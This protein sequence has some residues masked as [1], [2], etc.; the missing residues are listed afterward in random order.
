MSVRA[1]LTEPSGK[2][3]ELYRDL[4]NGRVQCTACARNC[5]I[6][7]GQVG[8]CGVRGVVGG[9]LYLL[10]YGKVM[11]GHIDPIEKKPVVHY[12]PGSKVFSIATSGCSWACAYC[13][14]PGTPVLTDRGIMSIDQIYKSS[15]AS[16]EIVFPDS[17]RVLSHT[18][19]W[20][21]VDKAFRH[22]Y[23]GRMLRIRPFYLPEFQC[24]PN[25]N[26]FV[27]DRVSGELI[28]RRADMLQPGDY[29]VVPRP[30]TTL[31]SS[32]LDTAMVLLAATRQSKEGGRAN[33]LTFDAERVRF[34][35][36]KGNGIP[37]II[38]LDEEF[39]ELLGLY[40]AEGSSIK[41]SRRPNSWSVCL[42]F[43]SHE[44]DL[45]V[46]AED[47]LRR[48]FGVS[49]YRVT[50]GSVTRVTVG[51]SELGTFLDFLMGRDCYSKRVPDIVLL[52]TSEAV[53]IGFLRGYMQGDGFTTRSGKQSWMGTTSVSQ[54]LTLGVWYLM[55]RR[56]LAP[57]FYVS[58]NRPTYEIEGRTV[59]RHNDY[60]TRVLIGND[61]MRS[62]GP[63]TKI[64]EMEENWL[65]PIR[66]IRDEDYEG[67]VYNLEIDEDHSYTTAFVAVSNCQN[68]DIS[69]L[70]KIEGIE[71]TPDELVESALSRG[72]E[73]MAYTY[74]QPTIFMEYARDV[75]RLARSKGLFNIFVSNGYDTPET[76][77][78]MDDF[79]DCVTVDFKGSGETNFVRRYIA[80]PN[81]D[82]I[83]QSLLEIKKRAKV[84]VEI[85]DLIVP[86]VGD[87]LDAARSLCR[88]VYDNLGPDM[89][90]HFLRFH[91]DYKMLD[92]PW[93]PVETLEKHVK[94]G[95]DAG[96][97]YVYIGNVTGHPD[98]STYCPGC[99]AVLIKRYGYEI[100]EYNLD[101]KNSCRACGYKTPIVGPLSKSFSEDR[102]VSVIS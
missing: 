21:F 79:L 13:F 52:N 64:L 61:S 40:A 86:R 48:I 18:G 54:A 87:S 69:Q 17:I 91:P 19:H 32:N 70:R 68:S 44:E 53:R 36:S 83:F 41:S 15:G 84:H 26:V 31:A 62:V 60:M 80:I 46:R 93:T 72:C 82:P 7:E 23:R 88:W 14:A 8:F 99:K 59:N 66:S 30:R 2:Q 90:I 77:A 67:H 76:V 96:L 55:F 35:R 1:R 65:V 29:L 58:S 33:R 25:H 10:V 20:K 9:K 95:R 71:A 73:G 56:G 43:G 100:L 81:A 16:E 39:G 97:R 50:Q 74:N 63:A 6:G 4:P 85:T 98:E 45:I 24:T 5:Q 28:K 22:R 92:F 102:F 78:M 75:G 11:A 51:S 47:L 89:P 12:R 49:P 94:I 27:A 101:E 38:E 42:S 3:A 34:T 57:R 37:R